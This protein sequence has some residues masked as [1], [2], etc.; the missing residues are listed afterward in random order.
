[1]KKAKQ[2]SKLLPE[3][4]LSAK[5]IHQKSTSFEGKKIVESR[6]LYIVLTWNS[7]VDEAGFEFRYLPAFLTSECRGIKAM[8]HYF[9]RIVG[10]RM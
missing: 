4:I 10:L 8:H 3:R 5:Q 1:M 9:G 7:C 6:S 2:I